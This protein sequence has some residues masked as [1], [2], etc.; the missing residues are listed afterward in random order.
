M[1]FRIFCIYCKK[2]IGFERFQIDASDKVLGFIIGHNIDY[3]ILAAHKNTNGET[4][5]PKFELEV[6]DL[7]LH[8]E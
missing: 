7:E 3:R 6:S 5:K 1:W 4:F 2:G 8:K